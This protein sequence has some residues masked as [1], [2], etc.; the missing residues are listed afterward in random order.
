MAKEV[1]VVDKSA[2]AMILAETERFEDPAEIARAIM[3]RILTADTPEAVLEQS[4]TTSAR[5]VLEVP[6]EL[7]DARFM[8][9][10]FDEGPGAYALLT[11]VNADGEQLTV[12]CG[13]RNVLA[14]V[15]RLKQLAALPRRVKF[16]EAGQTAQGYRPLWLNAA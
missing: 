14:Q 8:R 5:D 10:G 1:A 11:M 13:G 12:T 3:E 7:T 6:L 16:V 2:E 4:G 15:F 9:S